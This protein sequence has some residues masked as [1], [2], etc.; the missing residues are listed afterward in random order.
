MRNFVL[1]ALVV[2][3][4][5]CALISFSES[6]LTRRNRRAT[7]RRP[8]TQRV[9]C[10]LGNWRT[11]RS[12]SKTCGTG[13]SVQQRPVKVWPK[14]GGRRCPYYYSSQRYR[15][16]SCYTQCCPVNC[17]WTWNSWSPCQGCGVSQQNRTM[18]IRRKN[19]CGGNACPS[20]KSQSRSCNTG[21]WV[22]FQFLSFISIFVKILRNLSTCLCSPTIFF[23]FL[24]VSNCL[25]LAFAYRKSPY[26]RGDGAL[27]GLFA[28][29]KRASWIVISFSFY[30]FFHLSFLHSA[31]I[32]LEIQ[33][34]S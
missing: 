28:R 17:W 13:Y 15:T 5:L 32:G 22:C 29:E 33:H 27:M 9:D 20:S 30:I 34:K 7:R 18:R 21:M 19:T 11:Y 16:V 31:P 1:A 4:V 10:V 26:C 8:C 6:W 23:P 14:C 25:L 12:C 2:S 3:L 24:P